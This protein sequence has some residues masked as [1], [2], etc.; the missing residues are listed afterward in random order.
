MKKI[1]LSE[2]QRNWIYNVIAVIIAC[3]FLFPLYWIIINSFKMDGEIFSAVPTLW[4]K[5][6]TLQA[7][8]DQLANLGTT[9]KNSAIIAV[10]S[11]CI[12]LLLSVPAAYGLAKYKVR[13]TKLF[14]LIFLIT[15]M[16]PASLVLTPLFLIFSKLGLL[17]SYLAPILSTATISIPFI[18]L[19]LRPSFLSIPNEL[20]EAAK[21]DGCNI[22]SA[23]FRVIVPVAKPTIITAACF[24]FVYA[25]NDLA[26]SMTFNSKETMRPMTAAIYTFMNQYGTKW[27]SIM[28]Y[29]VLLILPSV[30]IFVTMQKHIV[31]GM[32]S[33]SV[34]G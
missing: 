34:K 30:I 2:R 21:I 13:G 9:L 10:G 17:N 4:P 1:H 28:A 12:S 20:V 22:V 27:N 5:T 7:Y 32:T 8:I 23:F 29:G 19:M 33:G 24:S 11:M 3:V 18:V 15:Q 14:V 31:E 6:F 26:Y 25:W 16:L